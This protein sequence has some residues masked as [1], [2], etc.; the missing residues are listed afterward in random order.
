[1]ADG[2]DARREDEP[3][4]PTRRFN[5]WALDLS[6]VSQ[7]RLNPAIDEWGRSLLT[8]NYPLLATQC[9]L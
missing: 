3:G 6:T 8:T 2:T 9:R 4:W 7:N 1:M 5:V